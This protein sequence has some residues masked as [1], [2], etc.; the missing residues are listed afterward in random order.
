MPLLLPG[1]P[2][3]SWPRCVPLCT[4]DR[5]NHVVNSDLVQSYK[6]PAFFAFS[7]EVPRGGDACGADSRHPQ[8]GIS[9]LSLFPRPSR[10]HPQTVGFLWLRRFYTH[11]LQKMKAC[12]VC[13]PGPRWWP[14][15]VRSSAC[16]SGVSPH[17]PWG[18]WGLRFGAEGW[19]SCV[20]LTR[21]SDRHTKNSVES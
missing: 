14:C 19:E 17:L 15:V 10:L 18:D 3:F 16:G 13:P 8:E 6:Q 12:R 2:P 9:A 5:C 11:H 7:W 4:S 20:I 1:F 21:S